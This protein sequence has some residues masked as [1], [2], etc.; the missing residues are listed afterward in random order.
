[1][2]VLLLIFCIC[3]SYNSL[4]AKNTTKDSLWNIWIDNNQSIEKKLTAIDKMV[5][6]YYLFS[7]P[8][9]GFY[10]ANLAY[11]LAVD[12]KMKKAEA[13]ALNTMG[14]SHS[15]RD[16]YSEAST[17]YNLSLKAWDKLNNQKGKAGALNNLSIIYKKQGDYDLAIKNL[18]ESLTIYETMDDDDGVSNA[19]NNIGNLYLEQKDYSNALSYH[20]R[21]LEACRHLNN[22]KSIAISLNN[23][24][25]IYKN[26]Q[27]YKASLKYFNESLELSE[28]INSEPDIANA[29]NS[30]GSVSLIQKKYKNAFAYCSKSLAINR[31][32]GRKLEISN[33]L[34]NIGHIYFEQNKIK[35]AISHSREALIIAQNNNMLFETGEAALLLYRSY[36]QNENETI[37][38]E[39]YE[40]YTE[41]KDSIH[42]EKNHQ[43]I[44]HQQIKYEYDKKKD[45]KD[46]EH[47]AELRQNEI[48]MIE[49]KKQQSIIV[50]SISIGLVLTLSFLFVLFKKLKVA[51]MQKNEILTQ[52]NTIET[53]LEDVTD[54]INYAKHLQDAIL[55]CH[56]D[57]KTRFPESFV[58]FNP[59]DAVSGDFYWFETINN[60]SYLA[61]ADCTGHGV[62]GAM[63]SV[64][65]SNALN[66][67]VF[68]YNLTAPSKILDKAR[69]LIISTFDKEGKNIKDGMD[70]VLCA[71]NHNELLYSG[72]HNPLWVIR[73]TSCLTNEQKTMPNVLIDGHYA[74]I[75]LKPTRQPVGDHYDIKPFNEEYL[76]LQKEDC[77]Y[78]FTDGYTDQFGGEKGKKYMRKRF[79]KLLLGIQHHSI[80]GQY[81]L[82]TEAFND[83]K[84]VNNQIDDVCV[85]GLKIV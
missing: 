61:V 69:E 24:G 71:F 5:W 6:D 41:V 79:K 76:P 70:I 9:S 51:R 22:D 46:L 80:H 15:L 25:L 10:Y 74:L 37:A 21:S 23:V 75:E 58:L 39:M 36:K 68:E 33:T 45:L 11:K 1:M 54:S 83:W 72:A 65:C 40:L 43:E 57:V 2:K 48:L 19:L 64:V 17:Y 84:G 59:K 52:K 27:K 77:L 14:V 26:Q 8:D 28:R 3:C 49:R 82:I 53:I 4:N 50:F 44:I 47:K 66:R 85:I 78:L 63:V 29:L 20:L 56:D 16:N 73:K 7:Q 13:E 30:L 35:E 32:I 34:N 38:L 60:I 31:K 55:P 42:S 81:H 67:T 12:R 18:T 62:P